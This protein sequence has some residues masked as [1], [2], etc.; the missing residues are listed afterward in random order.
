MRIRG[1]S[2]TILENRLCRAPLQLLRARQKLRQVSSHRL[3]VSA[4]ARA[5]SSNTRAADGF[6]LP[7]SH[8][9]ARPFFDDDLEEDADEREQAA[10]Q[11][12]EARGP[13]GGCQHVGAQWTEPA[14]EPPRQRHQLHAP[15]KTRAHQQQEAR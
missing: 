11:A 2:R 3:A 13:A 15:E 10:R 8:L 6:D 4:F 14:H 12:A 5:F 7:R 9:G 1:M